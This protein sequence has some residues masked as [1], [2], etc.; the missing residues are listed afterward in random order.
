MPKDRIN[1]LETKRNKNIRWT[2]KIFDEYKK[3]TSPEATMYNVPC[4]PNPK[5]IYD[6][7][8]FNIPH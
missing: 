3:N 2:V 6:K 7:G 4:N 1:E 5:I 8:A